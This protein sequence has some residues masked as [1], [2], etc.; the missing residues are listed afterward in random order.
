MDLIVLI[1]I[2]LFFSAFF[3]GMEIAF[4]TSNKLKI[5]LNNKQGAFSARLLSGFL[6]HPS[7]FIGTMLV[8]N[9]IALVLYGILMAR[10][11]EP[12]FYNWGL[13]SA[14]VLL[15]QTIV[16]TL[17]IL[18]A[19]EFLPKTLFRINSNFILNLFAVPLKIIYFIL[20]IPMYVMVGLSEL[21][22]RLFFGVDTSKQQVVFGRLDLSNYVR[23]I[24]QTAE[25]TEEELEHEIQIFQNALDF[26][27]VKARDCMVPRTEIAAVSVD[28]DL[29]KLREVFIDTG[30]SKAL[31]YRDNI[32]HI[33]GYVN[34]SEL[35]NNPDS[36]K[37]MI[38]PVIIIPET[39]SAKEVLELFIK[40][41]KSIAVV[42]DEFGGTSGILTIEDIIEEIFGDIE[43]EHDLE[44]FLE[45][46]IDD[47]T[48]HFAARLEIDYINDK[49]KLNLP[50]SD[51]YETLA[52][53]IIHT[54]AD[55]PE[56]NTVIKVDDFSFKITAVTNV[57][58]ETVLLQI[59]EEK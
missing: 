6:Q 30:F 56:L 44:E 47:H 29:K 53:F 46:K 16:S 50:E 28:D 4:L 13:T 51:E 18:F 12:V 19:G 34:S 25:G 27:K 26:S 1:A 11:L 14:S 3:S 41:N 38:V 35:F 42:V 33:I 58:I 31:V 23:E 54:Y 57:R 37:R 55:I 7:R 52:G 21:I 24:T 36:I 22:L 48:Y 17:I 43:D 9:N 8:G 40:Q 15:L 20:W 2:S 5:E 10:M 39:I 59:I 45:E 49:Y 32:D